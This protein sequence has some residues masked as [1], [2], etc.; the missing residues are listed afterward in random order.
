VAVISRGRAGIAISRTMVAVLALFA[1]AFIAL[2]ALRDGS[3]GSRLKPAQAE[4][5]AL[6]APEVRT[7]V[8]DGFTRVQTMPLDDET[9]RVSFFDGPRGVAEAAV[10]PDGRVRALIVH[11]GLH[12]RLG[13][14][15]GQRLPVLIGLVLLF[16][17]ATLR[18]PLARRENID[19]AALAGVA[20]PIVLVNE[21]YLEWS[22]LA[23]AVLLAYLMW[24]CLTVAT[25]RAGSPAPGSWVMDLLPRRATGLLAGGAAIGLVLL[26]IPGGLP[27]DVG[28]GSLA[29]AT[30]LVDGRLPYGNL[31]PGELVHG[32]TYPLLAYLA[33]V[34]AA[35]MSPVRD[36]FDNLD[37][38]L[39]VAT[40][41][42]LAAALG[43]AR[44]NGRRIAIAF[45]A[46][47][48]VMVAASSGSNDMV[49][50]AF[51]VGA[52]AWAARPGASSAAIALAGWVKLAPLALVPLWIARYRDGG[53]AHALAGAAAVTGSVA[54][55]VL[56]LGGSEGFAD[57]A[58]AI[59]FQS[60]RGSPMS[61]WALI[62]IPVAQ[63][64]FQA[65]VLTGLALGA[66]NVWRDRAL[67]SDPRRMAALG[68]AVLLAVQLAAN[69][70]TATYL[71]W[72]FPLVA[73]ALL[74]GSLTPARSREP[75][76]LRR[77]APR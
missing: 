30:E 32:D 65:A 33:Y 51:V 29:G 21:R 9:V 66:V 63:T 5:A 18:L 31:S 60:E 3:D 48:P 4:A 52:L 77:A 56:L 67:A 47:P 72:V 74:R 58:R 34:P 53:A 36:G 68:A 28:F 76:S 16:L 40:A 26:S 37:G 19:A 45:L 64:A 75:A 10:G 57:A 24:R 17:A 22:A 25:G 54:G 15:V 62:E 2:T 44:A 41:F 73:V 20:A 71:A 42:A 11:D 13:S 7:A 35:L 6:G 23:G 55:A 12:A 50:A 43:L 70:W 49:A 38:S 69:H 46:F 61:V 8:A 59:S 14:D 27:S 39:W 1:L